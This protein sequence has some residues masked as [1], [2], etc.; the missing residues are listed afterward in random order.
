MSAWGQKR[1]SH[2]VRVMSA[3]PPEADIKTDRR[4]VRHSCSGNFAR[5]AAIRRLTPAWQYLPHR[6]R[7]ADIVGRCAEYTEGEAAA[8][9]AEQHGRFHAIDLLPVDVGLVGEVGHGNSPC[10]TLPALSPSNYL[11]ICIGGCDRG[12]TKS[13]PVWRTR[14]HARFSRTND[15]APV[16]TKRT[17]HSCPTMS[18]FEAR[19]WLFDH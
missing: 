14:A 7:S 1:T 15:V 13:Q 11:V 9:K 18:A 16:G 4:Y 12:N 2:S 19:T 8:N 17:W 10:N 6:K 3:L 5:I